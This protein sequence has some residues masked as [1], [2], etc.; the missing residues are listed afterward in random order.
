MSRTTDDARS[1]LQRT[2]VFDRLNKK[3]TDRDLQQLISHGPCTVNTQQRD[4]STNAGCREA[5]DRAAY[6]TL[7]H[8]VTRALSP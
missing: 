2:V 5:K 8:S 3:A 4:R 1:R 6:T 7:T